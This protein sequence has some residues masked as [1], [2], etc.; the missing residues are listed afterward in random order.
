VNSPRFPWGHVTALILWILIFAAVYLYF[1]SRLQP[2]VATVS[3]L[4]QGEIRIP[5]S[6]DG[7]YYVAGMVNGHPLTF[8]VDTGASAVTVS[9]GFARQAG[10]PGGVP[11]R[12][13]TAGGVVTGETVPDQVVVAGGIRVSGLRVAVSSQMERHAPALLGQNF[14]RKIDVIQS[15]DQMVLRLKPG[16]PS[17]RTN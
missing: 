8:V 11:T 15:G 9:A 1:D 3:D 13:S 16:E 2:S 10:M 14:L 12:F 4:A 17:S 7:H 6:R 5:R